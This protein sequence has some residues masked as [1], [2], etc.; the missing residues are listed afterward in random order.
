MTSCGCFE[1]IVAVVPEANGV[2][3]VNRG[4]SGMTPI[5]MK[6]STIAGMIGG[7]VQTPGFMGVGVNYITSKKFLKGDGGLRRIV[8]MPKELK[9]RIKESFQ[10]RAEE[11]DI[12]DLLDKIADETV[13][14][15]VECLFDFL[16]KVGHP[17]LQMKPLIK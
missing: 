15:D 13:C 14:E 5:G 8:W 2:L 10:R 11:E 12:P 16:V 3:I 6:F 4:Y 7:G 9:E 17:A 1:C